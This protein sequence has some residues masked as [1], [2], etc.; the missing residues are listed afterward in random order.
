MG[1]L[2]IQIPE[3]TVRYTRAKAIAISEA[4]LSFPQ[5]CRSP[6][7][8]SSH[9]LLGFIPIWNIVIDPSLLFNTKSH[10][11]LDKQNWWAT[12][13]TSELQKWRFTAVPNEAHFS[14]PVCNRNWPAPQK[15]PP[16]AP[17]SPG[18]AA[19]LG[20]CAQ[21]QLRCSQWKIKLRPTLQLHEESQT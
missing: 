20:L 9:C 7:S 5:S 1:T 15:M 19:A 21:V 13:A 12:Q 2:N 8:G 3:M 16:R 17:S 14:F 6:G 10:N 4:P 18:K 11:L